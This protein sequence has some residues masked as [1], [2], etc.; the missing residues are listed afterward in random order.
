MRMSTWPCH[1]I[2]TISLS[3]PLSHPSPSHAHAHLI[4]RHHCPHLTC[5]AP[6]FLHFTFTALSIYFTY[7]YFTQIISI[8]LL[9]WK[10][11]WKLKWGNHSVTT[12]Y[13]LFSSS[14]FEATDFLIIRASLLGKGK[15]NKTYMYVIIGYWDTTSPLQNQFANERLL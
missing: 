12:S 13:N 15:L 5:V 3:G 14:K 6:P 9:K 8:L 1:H 7:L 4:T 10:L 2:T 11:T